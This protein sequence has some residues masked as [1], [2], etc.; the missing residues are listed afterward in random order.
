VDPCGS[1]DH[2]SQMG[3]FRALMTDWLIGWQVDL[4][5]AFEETLLKVPLRLLQKRKLLGNL[6]YVAG[7]GNQVN[8]KL[9]LSRV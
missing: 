1:R 3:T 4:A 8:L 5:G 9:L 2:Q 6:S 7:I